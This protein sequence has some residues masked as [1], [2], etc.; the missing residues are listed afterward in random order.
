ME[1]NFDV[2]VMS[3]SERAML[4]DAYK[5]I[6]KTNNW[7]FMRTFK[8]NPHEGFMLSSTPELQD[9]AKHMTQRHSGSTYAETMRTMEFIAKK[10]WKEFASSFKRDLA[11]EIFAYMGV[12]TDPSVKCPLH[13]DITSYACMECNH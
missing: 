6:T 5:A 10:G 9:I 11:R 4:A 1:G 3:D 7:E 2:L 13:P 8:P 12:S